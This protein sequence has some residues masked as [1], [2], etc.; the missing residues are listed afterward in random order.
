MAGGPGMAPGDPNYNPSDP[1]YNPPGGTGTGRGQ[2]EGNQSGWGN[3]PS[4]AMDR[5][6]MGQHEH[7]NAPGGGTGGY[8]DQNAMGGGQQNQNIPPS[9]ALGPGGQQAPVHSGH[10]T[11]GKIESAI[12]G[13]IGSK[14]LKAKG[15][16]K[17][18]E[19]Q[20]YK[21]QG[22]ELGEA[23]R[24]EKEALMRRERAVAHGAHPDHRHLGGVA[25]GS[26]GGGAGF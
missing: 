12:G 20:A 19:A 21:V 1:I 13:M 2:G 26:A 25:P 4:N 9:I 23:E 10:S 18:Q 8:S 16:Q 6:R 17:E 15:L 3:G 24:L 14:A 11:T 7:P 22:A 5:Q